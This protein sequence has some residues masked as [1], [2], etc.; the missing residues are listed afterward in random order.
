MKTMTAKQTADAFL[1]LTQSVLEGKDGTFTPDR[2]LADSRRFIVSRSGGAQLSISD[3]TDRILRS[4]HEV[5]TSNLDA[6]SYGA[7]KDDDGYIWVD[8]ND[9]YHTLIVA[10][11]VA[12]ENNQLAIYDTW[13]SRV[14]TLG[15]GA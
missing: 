14:I 11:K 3:P 8:A 10:M 13:E 6:E 7:W 1:F 12:R 5:V 15:E 9:S 4:I 2:E